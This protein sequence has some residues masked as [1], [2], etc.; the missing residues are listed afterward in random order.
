[1]YGLDDIEKLIAIALA[2]DIGQGDLTTTA[3]VS[4][5]KNGFARIIAKQDGILLFI[6]I[7]SSKMVT[8]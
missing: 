5:E 2:E 4:E 3:I 7:H 1:M 6:L 8:D